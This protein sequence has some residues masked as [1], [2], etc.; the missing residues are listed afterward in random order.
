MVLNGNKETKAATFLNGRDRENR[1]QARE[2]AHQETRFTASELEQY[3]QASR[4]QNGTNVAPGE[5]GAVSP[6]A[7]AAGVEAANTNPGAP[8]NPVWQGGVTPVGTPAGPT[9]Q[10]GPAQQMAASCTQYG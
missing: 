8:V 2:S 6:E 10:S 5:P 7:G 1:F 9:W 3:Y 4:G